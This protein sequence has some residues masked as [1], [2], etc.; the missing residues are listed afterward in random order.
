[1][2]DE[3]RETESKREI[4]RGERVCPGYRKVRQSATA[5]NNF[6]QGKINEREK[7]FS[8]SLYTFPSRGK[9]VFLLFINWREYF[10]G[11]EEEGVIG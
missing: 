3:E 9:L 7:L 4:Q 1:M 2:Y 5:G 10:K 6:F 11:Q 8:S